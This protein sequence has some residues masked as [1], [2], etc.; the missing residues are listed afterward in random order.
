[1][2]QV[3]G[4]LIMSVCFIGTFGLACTRASVR[5]LSGET[6]PT[7]VRTMGLGVGG[8]GANVAGLITPQAAYLGTSKLLTFIRRWE[9]LD[10]LS[11]KNNCM[12]IFIV[13]ASL[14]FF[15]FAII[16]V[17][18]SLVVFLMKETSGDPLSD[19]VQLCNDKKKMEKA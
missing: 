17:V 13:S 10:K 16:S 15:I 5:L 7:A 1:M 14:P 6:F 18:G 4:S 8:L 2:D 3:T 12:I 9:S 11:L 19:E